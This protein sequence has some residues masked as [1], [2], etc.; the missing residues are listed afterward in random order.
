MLGYLIWQLKLGNFTFSL[1][2]LGWVKLGYVGW[3]RSS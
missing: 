3:A 2:S 1:V